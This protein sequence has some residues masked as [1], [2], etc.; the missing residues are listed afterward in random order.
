MIIIAV[1][2]NSTANKY[3]TIFLILAFFIIDLIDAPKSAHK[4]IEGKHTKGA[5][6]AIKKV[7][8]KKFSSFGKNAVAAVKATTQALGLIN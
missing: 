6:T 4:Q 8:S 3:S 5:V 2:I 7:A 1:T